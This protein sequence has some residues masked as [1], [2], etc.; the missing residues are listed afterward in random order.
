MFSLLLY[1]PNAGALARFFLGRGYTV[2]V[3]AS[4]SDVLARTRAADTDCVLLDDLTLCRALRDREDG[5]PIIVLSERAS[6]QDTL[7]GFGAGADD[8]VTR[9]LSMPILQARIERLVS[10]VSA[11]PVHPYDTLVVRVGPQ[12]GVM[13]FWGGGPV[14]ET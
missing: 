10:K 13:L 8:Y 9:P 5:V 1:L 3:A 6:E 12:E 4:A 7:D 14:G 2:T 11:H